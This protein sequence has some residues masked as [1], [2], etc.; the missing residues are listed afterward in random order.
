[1]KKL[2]K[3]SWFVECKF[4]DLLRIWHFAQDF[5]NRLLAAEKGFYLIYIQLD[6]RLSRLTAAGVAREI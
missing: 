4:G 2:W 3:S 1:V 6:S 5:V